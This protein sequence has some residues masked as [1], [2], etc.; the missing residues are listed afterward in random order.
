MASPIRSPVFQS[1]PCSSS[2]SMAG[3]TSWLCCFLFRA[4]CRS[5]CPLPYSCSL[6][7]RFGWD[8]LRVLCLHPPSCDAFASLSAWQMHLHKTPS[9]KIILSRSSCRN[10]TCLIICSC[11]RR[12]FSGPPRMT[13]PTH[14][15]ASYA[16][17][18][19][20]C[21]SFSQP[22]VSRAQSHASFSF[23]NASL[24]RW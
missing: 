15:C 18:R 1:W 17:D 9:S 10:P 7:Y 20:S 21:F 22:F 16:A 4:C 11:T 12:S 8:L 6:W 14:C 5:S 2:S 19:R 13:H 23:W 24:L 3:S